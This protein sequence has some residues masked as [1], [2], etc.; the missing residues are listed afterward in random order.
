ME[1][2]NQY[3]MVVWSENSEEFRNAISFG[4]NEDKVKELFEEEQKE[5]N[6]YRVVH[7]GEGAVP[8]MT[9]RSLPYVDQQ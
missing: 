1:K 3:W 2:F 4:F 6:N 9:Y 7:I 8:P 5:K